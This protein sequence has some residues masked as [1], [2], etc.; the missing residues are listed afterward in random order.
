MSRDTGCIKLERYSTSVAHI[1]Y[2]MLTPSAQAHLQPRSHRAPN[3]PRGRGQGQKQE[4]AEQLCA[5]VYYHRLGGGQG[6][7]AVIA[8]RFHIACPRMIGENIGS[9]LIFVWT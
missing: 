4:G 9:N 8:Q 3:N 2:S 7:Q 1:A 5:G 6:G